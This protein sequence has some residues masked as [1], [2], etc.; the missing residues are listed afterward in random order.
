MIDIDI[1]FFI[2]FVNFLITLVVLN[3]ILIRPI[4]DTIRRRSERMAGQIGDI[5]SFTRSADAKMT[6]YGAALDAARRQGVEAKNALRDQ[7]FAQE[8]II[9][10]TA[11]KE[12][13]DIL[14]VARDAVAG[15]V[16]TA[17]TALKA[18]I[19]K[20]AQQAAAKILG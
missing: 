14:R 9:S 18:E 8:K 3:L 15:Q 11:G 7:G 20:L 6:E 13:S 2:Q 16:K 10:E 19:E 1:T 17:K 4:R 5:E 12:A